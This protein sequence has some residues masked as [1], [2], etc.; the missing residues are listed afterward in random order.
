MIST[1]FR[2]PFLVSSALASAVALLTL[3]AAAQMLGGSGL[4]SH[5]P[6]TQQNKPAE[7]PPPAVPGSRVGQE[8]VAPADRSAAD[9]QPNDALFDAINRGD[10]AAARDAVNRGA[11]LNAR[12]VLGMTPLDLSIDL[13]RNNISFLLLSLRPAPADDDHAEAKTAASTPPAPPKAQ[14]AAHRAQPA[15]ASPA[16]HAARFASGDGGRPIPNAGFLGFD[17]GHEAH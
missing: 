11:D 10:L 15:K 6:Q 9:L 7:P 2:R 8:V 1:A 16:T 5:A 3:P 17:M 14:L 12:N 4:S 13:G